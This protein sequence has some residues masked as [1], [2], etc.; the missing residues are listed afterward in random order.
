MEYFEFL[1][2]GD[3]ISIIAPSMSSGKEGPRKNRCDNAIKNFN[4]KKINVKVEKNCFNDNINARSADA[5]SR[6]REFENAFLDS[7]TKGII[8]IAGGEFELEILSFIDFNKIKKAKNKFF[9]GMSDNTCISFLLATI[10]DKASLYACNFGSFGSNRWHSSIKDNFN[11]LCGENKPQ[12]SFKKIEGE[13]RRRELGHELD[14]YNLTIKSNPKILS[15]EDNIKVSG[16]IV[17]G[18]LDILSHLCGT[19]FDNVKNFVKKYKDEGIIWFFESCDLNVL[20][21]SRCIW[22]LKNAGWFDNAK[23][24]LI[25]RPL[26]KET[27]YDCDYERCNYEHLKDFNVPVVIDLDIGHTDP[28]WYIVNGAVANFEMKNKTA[29]ISFA[30]K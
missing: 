30:L 15:G 12:V 6:A 23:A 24:F 4:K 19:K 22:K 7:S 25:G 10:C 27:L 17:G 13:N 29:K 2:K 1:N 21:Q 18:C 11:F 26:N 9:Q 14:G 3:F 20:E 16:R 8:A 5:V 28:T